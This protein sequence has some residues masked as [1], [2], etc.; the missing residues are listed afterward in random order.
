[1]QLVNVVSSDVTGSNCPTGGT[2]ARCR[3]TVT[4]LVPALTITQVADPTTTAAGS[5]VT[6]TV[7]IA[8]TGQL[9]YTGLTVTESLADI[10]DDAGYNGDITATAGVAGVAGSTLTWTGDLAAGA[11]ATVRYSVT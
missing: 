4:V 8:N 1:R 5:T 9:P 2:D 11:L 3:S 6:F 10:L 7:T